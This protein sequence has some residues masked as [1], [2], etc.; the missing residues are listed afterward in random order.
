MIWLRRIGLGLAVLVVLLLL[1]AV[2][3]YARGEARM[4]SF[5]PTHD[6]T[7]PIPTD[8]ASIER[9]R[10]VAMTRGCFGCHGE[11]LAGRS[12]AKEI[13]PAIIRLYA[14]NIALAARSE[15]P[16]QL[17]AAIRQGI[18]HDGRALIVMASEA[19]ARLSDQDTA[20]LIAFL[21]AQPVHGGA[22][23]KTSLGP[24]GYWGFINGQ[25]DGQL[26]PEK[27]AK[28]QLLAHQNDPDPKI[29]LGE[30]TT[31]TVCTHCHGADLH[32]ALPPGPGQAPDLGGARGYSKEDF[33]KLMR[34]GVPPDGRKLA[35]FMADSAVNEFS[36]FT[37]EE[38]DAIYTYL[39]ALPPK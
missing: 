11:D 4:T 30:Y 14:P 27:I 24:L 23:P 29:R 26:I 35:P 5:A 12:F 2:F 20:D 25:A 15:T 19:Y 8:A 31:M 10:H 39:N 1:F 22:Q 21:R 33:A 16:A 9:G 37:D 38:V 28:A 13:P 17:E 6:F 36:H 32:G 3:V 18:R 7:T 34:T